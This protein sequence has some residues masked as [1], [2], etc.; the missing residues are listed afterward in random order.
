MGLERLLD[1]TVHGSRCS[2][3]GMPALQPSSHT[4]PFPLLSSRSL[5]AIALPSVTNQEGL[6]KLWLIGAVRFL[7]TSLTASVRNKFAGQLSRYWSFVFFVWWR[8]KFS[9]LTFGHRRALPSV[10][11]DFSF[12]GAQWMKLVLL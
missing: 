4:S 1:C 6:C 10:R 2:H 7:G 11:Y 9:L 12:V 3:K 8:I 5:E